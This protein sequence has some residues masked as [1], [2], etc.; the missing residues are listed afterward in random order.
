MTVSKSQP[1][2]SLLESSEPTISITA[3][4]DEKMVSKKTAVQPATSFDHA[5]ASAATSVA[6]SDAEDADM[7][8]ITKARKLGLNV[9][10]LDQSVPDRVVRIIL[11][12]DWQT[13][14]AEADD[15]LRRQRLYIVATDLSDE[16]VYALEWTIGT[17]LRDGDTLLAF[18]AMGDETLKEKNSEADREALTA[19]GEKAARE[20]QMTMDQ[21]TDKTTTAYT[22]SQHLSPK[23]GYQPATKTESISGSVDARN[24]SKAQRERLHAVE[25]ISSTCVRLLRKTR[26]QVRI[27]VEV[28]TC[29]SPKHLITGAVSC[30]LLS[31]PIPFL[32]RSRSIHS[33]RPSSFSAV[34]AAQPLKVCFW[35]HSRITWLP[36]P[37]CRLWWLGRS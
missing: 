33:T 23:L 5:T 19:E 4:A 25:D 26:L 13:I 11:R 30:L 18:C 35:G 10:P 31:P 8:D 1:V 37:R 36:N 27:C 32:M 24:V 22:D 34:V 6:S 28:V 21:L 12:G 14:Q 29:R 16:S 3:P 17:I 15:G 2:Q 7:A 20:A 9:S